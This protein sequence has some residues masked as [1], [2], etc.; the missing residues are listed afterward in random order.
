MIFPLI[1]VVAASIFAVYHLTQ[2]AR[3]GPGGA[4]KT[5][6]VPQGGTLNYGGQGAQETIACNDGELNITGTDMTPTVTGH[7]ARLNVVD[8]TNCRVTVDSA[9]EIN[10]TGIHDVVIYNSGSPQ[11]NNQG[12]DNTVEQASESAVGT[13]TPKG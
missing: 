13:P 9:D 11:V 3:S 2:A 4:P 10:V 12:I 6:S 7:C 5:V 1:V 8:C